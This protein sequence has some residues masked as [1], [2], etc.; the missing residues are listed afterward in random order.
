VLCYRPNRN[1]FSS[2]ERLGGVVRRT[3]DDGGEYDEAF[4]RSLARE[5][6]PVLYSFER[7]NRDSMFYEITQDEANQIVDRIRRIVA[8]GE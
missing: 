6:T 8:A 5:R 3:Q 2:K 4:T 1:E 7:R